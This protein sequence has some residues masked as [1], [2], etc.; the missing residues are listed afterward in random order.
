MCGC[1]G[2]KAKESVLEVYIVCVVANQFLASLLLWCLGCLRGEKCF[3]LW[4][5]Y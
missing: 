3:G 4:S 1:G 5:I 2:L